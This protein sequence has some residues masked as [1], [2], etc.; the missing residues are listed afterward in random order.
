MREA[1]KNK[2]PQTRVSRDFVELDSINPIRAKPDGFDRIVNDFMDEMGAVGATGSRSQAEKA[3]LVNGWA[4]SSV[5]EFLQKSVRPWER[6]L[7]VRIPLS[8]EEDK[9]AGVLNGVLNFR[10]FLMM[11]ATLS[12]LM[13]LS[14]IHHMDYLIKNKIKKQLF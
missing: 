4:S 1:N 8:Y 12:V 6:A 5:R 3:V 10:K 2:P 11:K 13:L 9:G 7:G 14:V